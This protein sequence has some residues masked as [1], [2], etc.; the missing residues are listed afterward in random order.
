MRALG[1]YA[2]FGLV[3]IGVIIAALWPFLDEASRLGVLAAA[4]IAYPV[5]VVAF[6][7][8]LRAKREPERFLLWWG[9]GILIRMGVVIAVGIVVSSTEVLPPAAT[10]LGVAGFFFGMLLMEPAF[11]KAGNESARTT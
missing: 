4:A 6:G 1:R 11:F 7:M 5:Q 9:L 10:L 8:L 3:G 2:G